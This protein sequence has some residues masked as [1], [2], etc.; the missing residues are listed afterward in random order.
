MPPFLFF[1]APFFFHLVF[2]G[3]VWFHN[4]VPLGP[5]VPGIML[6]YGVLCTCYVFVQS[7]AAAAAAA[8]CVAILLLQLQQ[9]LLFVIVCRM[10]KIVSGSLNLIPSRVFLLFTQTQFIFNA[11]SLAVAFTALICLY[12]ILGNCGHARSEVGRHP[13]AAK[14]PL[15][16]VYFSSAMRW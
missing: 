12:Y 2:V 15:Y 10:V 4:R 3:T 16:H 8:V 14:P 1:G 9:L 5:D 11:P 7:A 13:T 6:L